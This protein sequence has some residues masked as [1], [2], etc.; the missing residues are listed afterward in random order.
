MNALTLKN[1]LREIKRTF[2][3]FLSI[4][5]I[6]A[7]GVAFFAGIRATSPDMKEAG[8]RL[9]NTYNLS[10]IS[11]IS[12]SGLTA[13]NIRDLESI[14]GI[15]AVRASLFVDAM[16]RGTGEKEKNLRLYS[17]PIK[18]KSEYAPLIDLI[19]DYGIDTSPEYEMNGVEIVSGRMPLNDTETALDY[20]L[21]GSLVKQLGDEITLT[22]SGGTVMLRVVGFI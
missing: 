15:R 1:L 7:L 8:D 6:C 17:M 5:A 10:D 9:Y 3:K 12:T 21:E 16:A 13:D 22:T 20:T 18:L 2:T 14:E 19:P 11:V 4:F